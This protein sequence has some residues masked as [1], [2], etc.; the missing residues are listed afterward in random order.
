MSSQI[1]SGVSNYKLEDN[2]FYI[3]FTVVVASN[4]LYTIFQLLHK[5]LWVLIKMDGT[6]LKERCFRLTINIFECAI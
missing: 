3:L 6:S 1:Q 4:N 5:I 2:R